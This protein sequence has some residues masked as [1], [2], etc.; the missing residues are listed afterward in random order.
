MS[1]VQS[2][3]SSNKLL[4]WTVELKDWQLLFIYIYISIYFELCTLSHSCLL[5]RWWQTS[6]RVACCIVSAVKR[7]CFLSIITLCAGIAECPYGVWKTKKRTNASKK[8]KS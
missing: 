1:F 2:L 4:H 7:Y 6:G 5:H 8:K 3:Q